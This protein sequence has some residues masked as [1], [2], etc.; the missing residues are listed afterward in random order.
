MVD[1]QWKNRF[2]EVVHEKNDLESPTISRKKE[3]ALIVLKHLEEGLEEHEDGYSYL[4]VT[5]FSF[6]E[7]IFK[8]IFEDPKGHKH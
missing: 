5:D 4:E 3:L 2:E 6:N 8:A 1:N 7:D